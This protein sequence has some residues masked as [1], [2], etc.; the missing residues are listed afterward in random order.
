MPTLRWFAAFDFSPL[1]RASVALMAVLGAGLPCQPRGAEVLARVGGTDVTVEVR[2]YVETL[3]PAD[4]A[5]LGG[6]LCP[7]TAVAQPA[8]MVFASPSP[9]H[10]SSQRLGS[11]GGGYRA[12]A[13]GFLKEHA[14]HSW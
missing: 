6:A 2:S 1:R 4:Q 13:E 7:A 5:A 3:A 9:G 10:D 12:H 8:G 11:T 14:K